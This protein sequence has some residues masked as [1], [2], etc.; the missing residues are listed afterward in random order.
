MAVVHVNTTLVTF[1]FTVH[2]TDVNAAFKQAIYKVTKNVVVCISS[3]HWQVGM[4]EEMTQC[5]TLKCPVSVSKAQRKGVYSYF[6]RMCDLFL[7]C[8]VEEEATLI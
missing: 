7:S 5:F 1:F 3:I 2:H 6:L 4:D 8:T